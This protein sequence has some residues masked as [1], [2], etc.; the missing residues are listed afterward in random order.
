M[1]SY[2]KEP[3]CSSW[4]LNDAPDSGFCDKCYYKNHM[5]TLLAMIHRDGGH[6]TEEIGIDKSVELAIQIVSEQN[7]QSEIITYI[8]KQPPEKITALIK[9]FELEKP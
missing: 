6:K 7:S 4:A 5:K 1:N 8:N 9:L 3:G 2:C